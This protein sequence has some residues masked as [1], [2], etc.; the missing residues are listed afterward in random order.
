MRWGETLR[1]TEDAFF[2][3]RMEIKTGCCLKSARCYYSNL[4]LAQ[5]DAQR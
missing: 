4:S 3:L 5:K 1:M 2:D